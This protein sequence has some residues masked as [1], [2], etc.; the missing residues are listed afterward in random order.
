MD[1]N[2]ATPERKLLAR[3][4]QKKT[5]YDGSIYRLLP[6]LIFQE[7]QPSNM[8]VAGKVPPQ[9]VKTV[10]IS[11]SIPIDISISVTLNYYPRRACNNK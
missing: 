9:A 10:V 8:M 4:S 7:S 6:H 2:E 1:R 5:N 3:A 11:R